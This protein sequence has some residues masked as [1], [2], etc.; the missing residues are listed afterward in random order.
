MAGGR[1]I[2]FMG[3]ELKEKFSVVIRVH[4]IDRVCQSATKHVIHTE[5]RSLKVPEFVRPTSHSLLGKH[6][7]T[8]RHR[9][10]NALI[11]LD[12]LLH[13]LPLLLMSPLLSPAPPS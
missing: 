13:R 8:L 7:P 1:G 3:L 4:G 11:S 2:N 5:K 10:G 9:S 12:R 6:L